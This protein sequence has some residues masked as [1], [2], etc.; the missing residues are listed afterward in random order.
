MGRITFLGTGTSTGIPEIGCECEVCTSSDP[1][2]RRYRTSAL[3]EYQG[4][5]ILIDCGPDFRCQL[6]EN[7]VHHLD[8]ICITHEHYDHTGGL[9][10]LRPLFYRSHECPIYTEPN[11]I[12]AIKLRL[13]YAFAEHKYPGV[14]NL[15]LL[16]LAPQVPLHL[17]NGTTIE[18]FRVLHGKLPILGFKV[19][20]L[21]Y[22]TDCKQLPTESL[23][24]IKGVKILVINALRHYDH[25]AHLTFQEALH[26]IEQV[27]PQQAYLT[28]FAHTFGKHTDIE[29][30]CPPHVAPA[31]DGL[32]AEF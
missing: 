32:T 26:I 14:P 8:A 3:I 7:H 20:A 22:I 19:G 28:H 24:L 9:D 13:P 18:P 11:V 16:P 15:Q 10:D 25:P 30:L 29:A 12:K 6:I 31:Y 4:S 5:N 21:A 2:N 27:A 17:G 1:R 23:E